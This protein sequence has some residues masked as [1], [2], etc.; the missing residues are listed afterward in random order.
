M[1]H[2]NA[3]RIWISQHVKHVQYSCAYDLAKDTFSKPT[4]WEDLHVQVVVGKTCLTCMTS[5]TS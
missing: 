4:G 2:K 5:Q 3:P 1:M